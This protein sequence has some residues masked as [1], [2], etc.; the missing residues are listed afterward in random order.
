M[1]ITRQE[2]LDCFHSD[3]LIGLGM[4]ADAIRRHLHPEGVVSYSI[5]GRHRLHKRANGSG[6][7]PL[8]TE[9]ETIVAKGGTSAT[10]HGKINPHHHRRMV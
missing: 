10:L 9:V 5:D 3:D 6:F 2:A 7:E 4:E 8:F 1:G